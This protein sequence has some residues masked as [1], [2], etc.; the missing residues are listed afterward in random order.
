LFASFFPRPRVF[1]PSAVLWSLAAIVIWYGWAR[2]FGARLGFA[3]HG[4]P[5][6]GIAMFWAKP[7]LWFDLYFAVAVAIFAGAWRLASSHPWQRWSV[8][9]SA[10]ILFVAY[11]QVEVSVGVN[12]WYGPFWDLV[13][14]ALSHTAHVTT[15]Q[16]YGQLVT[17]LWLALAG[18]TIGVLTQ[19]FI[20]H[21]IFRWRTAMNDHYVAHWPK[22]RRIEGA[23]QRIQED[24][25]R[26]SSTTEDLGLAFVGSVMTL[27]AFIP[28]LM[29][30]SAHITRLPLVGD[31]PDALVIAA[32]VWAMFGTGFLAVVGIRLPGL[33]F[34]NQRV[35]AAYRKEL[36]FGEDNHERAQPPTLAEL[37]SAVRGNYF[38]LY[39][40]Y[41]YFNVAR[42]AY[43]QA[44]VVFSI[45]VLGPSVIAGVLTFGLLQQIMGAFDQVRGSFQYLVNSWSTIIE[46]QS[47]YKRLH[48]FE[49]E[50]RG[51]PPPSIEHAPDPRAHGVLGAPALARGAH[52]A[53]GE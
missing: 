25:M 49:A 9:G 32:I 53:P 31:L 34:R 37:F 38:K 42:M 1:F 24:T 23:A 28:V 4:P 5:V 6:I 17:F 12:N 11:L 46:L 41:V 44:D 7:F 20:S 15:A 48:A 50:I 19:F 14:A 30:L 33:Q 43:L 27:I 47:I 2:G 40:N 39:F 22:L 36:V 51:A 21:Y 10:L 8:L 16:Y 3:A 18:V 45:V 29:R 52:P 26:F 13:Q 35:E